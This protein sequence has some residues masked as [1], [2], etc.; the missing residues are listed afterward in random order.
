MA[1]KGAAIPAEKRSLAKTKTWSGPEKKVLVNFRLK[2]II[3]PRK[4]KAA[5]QVSI[6]A[7]FCRKDL[8]AEGLLRTARRVF[9]A[10]PEEPGNDIALVDQTTSR[11]STI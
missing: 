4:P 11:W 5:R 2:I 1:V 8:S 3:L 10:I 6:S 7:P 9:A